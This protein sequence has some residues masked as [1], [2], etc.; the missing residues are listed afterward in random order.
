MLINISGESTAKLIVFGSGKPLRQFIYSQDLAKLII[1]V[2]LNYQDHQPIILSVGEEDE[3]SIGQA[4]Q[5][6]ADSFSKKFSD[7]SSQFQ[8]QIEYDLNCSDGQFKKTANNKKLRGFL[9]H[10]KF[11]PIQQGIYETVNWFCDN[12][13]VARK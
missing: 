13:E 4:A 1:W 9:P 10:F 12:Y 7:E 8:I 5:L 6:I 3:I 2:L 11:T